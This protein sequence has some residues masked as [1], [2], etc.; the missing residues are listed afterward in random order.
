MKPFVSSHLKDMNRQNVYTLFCQKGKTSKSE[1]S[2]LTGISAPTVIK[3]IH[4]MIEKNLI[5]ELGE[6]KSALG[7]KPQMLELNWNRY[8]SIGIVHE[9]TY[10][11]VGLVNLA[12]QPIALKKVCV[13]GTLENVLGETLFC[14][15]NQLLVENNVRLCDALGIGL[16]IP[17]MY[18]TKN[19]EILVAPLIGITKRTNISAIIQN[20][21]AQYH[22]EVCVENDLNM[23]VWG[24]FF[25]L[26]LTEK[27]D[28][29]Y[30]SVGTGVGCGVILNGKLRRGQNY[31]CGEVGYM[32]FLDDYDNDSKSAG[33][34]ENRINLQFLNQEFSI[35]NTQMSEQDRQSII[36]Y[37][38]IYCTLCI[39]NIMMCYDS[40]NISI[41]GEVFDLLGD[42]LF[43]AVQKR[44]SKLPVGNIDIRRNST[45]EPGILGAAGVV[46]NKAIK[47]I[48]EE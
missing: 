16:G 26:K 2:R 46:M 10:L 6:G 11:K 40:D 9:G 20:I 48:L 17:G 14:I 30:L 32:T 44:I 34:L 5:I 22:V 19:Q 27:N 35:R 31:M 29:I 13:S 38:S 28:L 41:G 42:A 4:F 47:K 23:E 8:F 43:E 37:V 1:I 45:Q 7:R 39:N 33:W 12:N 21:K 24:E 36:E 15:V 25:S 3:I 18:D